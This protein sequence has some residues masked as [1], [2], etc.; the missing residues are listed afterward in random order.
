MAALPLRGYLSEVS[1]NCVYVTLSSFHI[2]VTIAKEF[3]SSGAV[4]FNTQYVPARK[5]VTQHECLWMS[6]AI[7]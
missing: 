6:H 3:S 5:E 7:L 4:T 2:S 1:D